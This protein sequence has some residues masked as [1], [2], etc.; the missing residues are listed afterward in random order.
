MT[1]RLRERRTAHADTRRE[2][3]DERVRRMQHWSD[4]LEFLRDGATVTIGKFQQ[5]A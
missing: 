5:R 2:Y 3:W 4:H 1:V